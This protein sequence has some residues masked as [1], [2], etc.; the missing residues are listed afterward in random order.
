MKRNPKH[1]ISILISFHRS[2]V[3]DKSGKELWKVIF[4]LMSKREVLCS[5]F[6]TQGTALSSGFFEFTEKHVRFDEIQC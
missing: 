4:T 3:L 6:T 5:H 1:P 2:Q